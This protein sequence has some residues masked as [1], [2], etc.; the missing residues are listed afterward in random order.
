MIEPISCVGS[1]GDEMDWS[2]CL[3]DGFPGWRTKKRLSGQSASS[4]LLVREEVFFVEGRRLYCL[5]RRRVARFGGLCL[6]GA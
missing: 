2:A 3:G 6:V 1:D 4:F 5:G